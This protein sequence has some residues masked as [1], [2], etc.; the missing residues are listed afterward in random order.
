MSGGVDSSVGA[1]LLAEAG[2]NVTG[3]TL[4]LWCYGESDEA[5]TPRACCS[6]DAIEDARSVAR[7]M[8]FPHHVIDATG[9][10]RAR[11]V[12]PFV[13]DYRSGFTPYPCAA[14]NTHLKFGAL[15]AH[16]RRSGAEFL[17]TGHYVRSARAPRRDGSVEPALA[18]AAHGG[19]DQAYAL[20]G[21][22]RATLPHLVFPLGELTK[23]EVRAHGARLGLARVA[24][25]VESQ[26]LCFVPDGDYAGFV[27]G[28]LAA[29]GTPGAG[30]GAII[31]Q[32]GRRVGTHGGVAGFT[33]GQRRG[34]GVAADQPLYV[35]ALEP[36]TNTVRVGPEAALHSSTARFTGFNWLSLD[37]PADGEPV[38]AQIRYRHA[39]AAARLFA[40]AGDGTGRL[41]FAGPQR[42]ITPGQS[43]AFYRGDRLLGGAR[44]DRPLSR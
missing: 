25:K 6:L 3:V 14:C 26:D 9:E 29:A 36:A 15:F 35:T 21:I 1:A 27:A 32:D 24:Q 4:K 23:D 12:A 43:V 31:D 38:E 11:V 16:A 10:F 28:E 5:A 44:L 18:R 2:W 20:W 19:K 34:L 22:D 39:P 30:A 7:R 17:S 13:E 42:A 40:G 37:P 41:E 33:V 8:D